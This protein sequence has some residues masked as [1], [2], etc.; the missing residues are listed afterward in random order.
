MPLDPIHRHEYINECNFGSLHTPNIH[1][2]I[3]IE[4]KDSADYIGY[5]DVWE[6]HGVSSRMLLVE[7]WSDFADRLVR[8][9][10]L[11]LAPE[12]ADKSSTQQTKI[13]KTMQRSLSR[14]EEEL[15]AFFEH[16]HVGMVNVGGDIIQIGSWRATLGVMARCV[17]ELIKH[18]M[19]SDSSSLTMEFTATVKSSFSETN[20]MAVF[21][22]DMLSTIYYIAGWHITAC[23]KAG[24]IRSGKRM[25][26]QLGKAMITLFECG[27]ADLNDVNNL[28][29]EKVIRCEMFGGLN[30]VSA[31]YYDFILKLEYVFVKCLTS[32]K[33]AVLGNS[34]IQRISHILCGSVEVRQCV[35]QVMDSTI[36]NDVM[37]D[38]VSY[39]IQTYCRMRGKDFCRQIMATN[40]KNLGKGIRPTMAVLSDKSS[41]VK[42]ETNIAPDS[43]ALQYS[44][45][46]NLTN[47]YASTD[48]EHNLESFDILGEDELISMHI[49]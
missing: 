46:E 24:R 19:C 8:A 10:K 45:F 22:S 23:L 29:T 13:I 35:Q 18:D 26:G 27:T 4:L 34:I 32:E 37:D 21:P 2:I 44:L 6:K 31:G 30:C 40:F 38:L 3:T 47:F 1:H 49:I 41:Y 16:E 17:I 14:Y 42:K 7:L 39:L 33:L 12:I 9:I 25:D 28:P 36:D 43:I 20:S 11:S 15:I 5:S 48:I